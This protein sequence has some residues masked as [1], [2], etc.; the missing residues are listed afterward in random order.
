MVEV[1][2]CKVKGGWKPMISVLVVTSGRDSDLVIPQPELKIGKLIELT[3][4][5]SWFL[6]WKEQDYVGLA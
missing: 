6:K 1:G 4:L 2:R 3:K 5:G